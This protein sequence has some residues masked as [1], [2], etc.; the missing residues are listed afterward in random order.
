M[1][2]LENMELWDWW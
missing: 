1:S 2:D